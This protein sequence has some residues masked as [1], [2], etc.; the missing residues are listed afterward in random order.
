MTDAAPA[1][2]PTCFIAMPLTTRPEDVDLH[3]DNDHWMHVLDSLFVPAVRAA[4]FEPIRPIATGSDIIHASIIKQLSEADL[5]LC[6]LSSHNPNVFFELGMRTAANRPIALVKDE[7]TKLPFDVQSINT[8]S[9]KSTLHGWDMPDEL[10]KLTEHIRA[11]AESSGGLNPL[12][13]YFGLTIRAQ[14]PSTS[15]SPMEAKVEL[16]AESVAALQGEL[17]D[18]NRELQM[19]LQAEHVRR[20]YLEETAAM[21]QAQLDQVTR[22]RGESWATR[23]LAGG[24]APSELFK[25][26]VLR[27]KGLEQRYMEWGL[28]SPNEVTLTFIRMPSKEIRVQLEHLAER[29]EVKLTMRVRNKGEEGGRTIELDAD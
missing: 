2:L 5:V 24:N 20:S 23:M 18:R 15:S 11:C 22:A 12:W 16:I 28:T 17:V 26:A 14:E 9:Y 7:H 21:Q 13:H 4:G 29:Y 6:D 19:A 3:D 27:Q 25:A 10:D 8:H 1:K